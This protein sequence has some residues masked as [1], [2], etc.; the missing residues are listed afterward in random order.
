M[1]AR[2]FPG[3][4]LSLVGVSLAAAGHAGHGAPPGHVHGQ[5]MLVGLAFGVV[6]L[7]ALGFAKR[8]R[9]TRTTPRGVRP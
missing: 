2:G 8:R 9:A 3:I 6:A 1:S 4:A 7:G 5:F